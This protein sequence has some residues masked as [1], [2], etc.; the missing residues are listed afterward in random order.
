MSGRRRPPP[1]HASCRSPRLRPAWA[2]AIGLSAVLAGVVAAASFG[3]TGRMQ[4][5][6]LLAKIQEQEQL[7]ADA[8]PTGSTQPAQPVREASVLPPAPKQQP[9]VPSGPDAS[10]AATAADDRR[11]PVDRSDVAPIQPAKSHGPRVAVTTGAKRGM[12]MEV[13]SA[14]PPDDDDQPAWLKPVQS[15]APAQRANASAS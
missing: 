10:N 12:K 15:K 13:S 5:E 6:N 2:V 1:P 11:R 3:R 4:P 7:P 9:L 8:R 14:R